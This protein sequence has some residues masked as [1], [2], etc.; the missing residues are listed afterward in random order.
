MSAVATSR[1]AALLLL[2]AAGS[3]LLTHARA[4]AQWWKRA[5]VDFEE[6]AA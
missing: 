2:T 4:E 3:L 1:R 5:P 6:C